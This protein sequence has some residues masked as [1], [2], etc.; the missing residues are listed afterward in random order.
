M[1]YKDYT[2]TELLQFRPIIEDNRII[3]VHKGR[4]YEAKLRVNE[5]WRLHEQVPKSTET[6][7]HSMPY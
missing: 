5:K 7:V 1:I 4:T 2:W 6:D 3:I